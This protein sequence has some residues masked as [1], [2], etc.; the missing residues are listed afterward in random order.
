MFRRRNTETYLLCT[1]PKHLIIH[2]KATSNL[3]FRCRLLYNFVHGTLPRFPYFCS[4]F[5]VSLSFTWS[6]LPMTFGI[7]LYMINVFLTSTNS[8]SFYRMSCFPLI[9]TWKRMLLLFLV[10]RTSFSWILSSYLCLLCVP[11]LWFDYSI[12]SLY[13]KTKLQIKL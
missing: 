4:I 6:V 3:S 13:C 1:M 10:V 12:V 11:C 5:F 7:V 9:K 2:K 8:A